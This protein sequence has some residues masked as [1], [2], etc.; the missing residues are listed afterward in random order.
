AGFWSG[1]DSETG[2]KMPWPGCHPALTNPPLHSTPI[3]HPTEA[4]SCSI[5]THLRQIGSRLALPFLARPCYAKMAAIV[6][7]TPAF[8]LKSGVPSHGTAYA[9]GAFM[10]LES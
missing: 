1:A 3:H 7:I 4:D 9:Y 2:W 5:P 6:L 10:G 8:P